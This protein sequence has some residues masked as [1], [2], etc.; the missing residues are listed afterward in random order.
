MLLRFFIIF[1]IGATL[2]NKYLGSDP[3]ISE[4]EHLDVMRKVAMAISGG[5]LIKAG[6]QMGCM[7]KPETLSDSLS[8]F[9]PKIGRGEVKLDSGEKLYEFGLILLKGI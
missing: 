5:N 4:L 9:L 1:L 7:V 8:E 3:K 6:I 2:L